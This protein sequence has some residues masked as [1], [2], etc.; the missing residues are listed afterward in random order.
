MIERPWMKH[1]V[2]LLSPDLRSEADF[3]PQHANFV[4]HLSVYYAYC[5]PCTLDDLALG[6]PNSIGK[7]FYQ[8]VILKIVACSIIHP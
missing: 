7:S 4:S 6:L 8:D 2:H 1:S 3:S 5:F